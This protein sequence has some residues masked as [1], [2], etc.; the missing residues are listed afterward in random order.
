M[1][2]VVLAGGCQG[3]L[4][5]SVA[6]SV[7]PSFRWIIARPTCHQLTDP[8]QPT[9]A[10][11]KFGRV[12]TLYTLRC[13]GCEQPFNVRLGIGPSKM[14]GFYVPCAHCSLP[15]RG[16]SHGQDLESHR[17]EFE[18][19]VLPSE[20]SI[21]AAFVTVDPNVPSKYNATQRGELGTFTTMTLMFLV[22]SGREED[23]LEVLSRGRTAVEELWP[24]VRRIYEYYLVEDWKHFDKAGRAAFDDWRTVSTTHERA[25]L[26]HQ[27]VGIVAAAITDDIDDSAARYL[28]RFHTKHTSALKFSTYI[29]SARAD[30]AS[31]LV[32][33]L[34]RSVFDVMD[35]FI[36]HFDAW[37]MG[38]LR[39][40][41]P[42]P[43]QNSSHGV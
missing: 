20:N 7:R 24:K 6:V 40:V 27:A 19:E 4:L 13:P 37:Q 9:S 17:V 12:M 29:H 41:M 31:E 43:L 39:R 18:A 5:Y 33:R 11:S 28:H 3:P 22:G 1:L 32:P 26:A 14:T 10:S 21:E 30:V 34:Q 16:R 42:V 25:T 23:L 38:V 36:G 35:R 2:A 8:L 15:I